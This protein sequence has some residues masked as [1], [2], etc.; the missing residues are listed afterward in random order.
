MYFHFLNVFSNLSNR[1]KPGVTGDYQPTGVTKMTNHKTISGDLE[2]KI[3]SYSK[4]SLTTEEIR[5]L[6]S[7]LIS[8]YYSLAPAKQPAEKVIRDY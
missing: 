7:E 5:K 1:M 4:G 6:W 8:A 2:K 3:E